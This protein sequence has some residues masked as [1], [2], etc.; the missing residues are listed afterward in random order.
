MRYDEPCTLLIVM[1]LGS[2]SVDVAMPGEGCRHTGFT[3]VGDVG[4][5]RDMD[6]ME[7]C[8]PC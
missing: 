8:R 4:M 7:G 6:G 3:V 2:E 1:V 5:V